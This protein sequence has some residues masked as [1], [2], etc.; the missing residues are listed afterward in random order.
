MRP[1]LQL[2]ILLFA[3][4]SHAQEKN[5]VAILNTED[6]GTPEIEFTNLNFLTGKLR[7]IA[8]KVLPEDKYSVMS[9]Q[10]IIDKLGSR[11]NAR[12]VCKAAQCLAEIGRK[13]NATYVGQ[14]RLGRLDDYITINMELYNSASG[15]LVGSFT[16]KAKKVSGLEGIITNNAPQMFGKMPGVQDRKAASV[17]GGISDLQK[18]EGYDL[19]SGRNYLVNLSSEPTDAF[20][21]FDGVPSAKCLKTPCKAELREGNIRIIAALEQYETADTTVFITR[22]NQN[23]AIK[24]KPNFGFLEIKPAYLDGIGENDEW[25]LDING[26]AYHSYENKFSPGN[27]NVKLNHRCYEAISFTA[28]I[29]KGNREIFDMAGNITLKKG[30]LELSAE[31]N[32]EPVSEPVFVNKRQMG[33]TPFSDAVPL[34]AGIEI[35][36]KREVVRVDLKYNEKVNYTHKINIS[37]PLVPKFEMPAQTSFWV[38]IALDV[39]GAVI[40]YTGHEKDNEML[41]AYGQYKAIMGPN[42]F[43]DAWEKA[44]SLRSSRNARY[45]VGSMFLVSGVGVHIWF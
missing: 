21:S 43:K 4:A 35:G 25:K 45:V 29:N 28:G 12:Q 11:E 19:V 42:G 34:C 16:G 15:V 18:T 33:E 31:R 9:V 14:A 30:G 13:V 8:V 26:K 37:E 40:I 1:S 6:D 36:E 3:L 24:L 39:L 23:I 7:E 41:D 44:E 10:S 17:A 5:R 20:L 32:G 2:F 38:A 22:N 27:Y